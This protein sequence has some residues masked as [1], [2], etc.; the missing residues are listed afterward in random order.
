MDSE[1][2][3]VEE[4]DS[5]M[6]VFHE[7]NLFNGVIL[8]AEEDEIIYQSAFGSSNFEWG[9]P[10][11]TNTRFKMASITKVYTASL[12]MHLIERGKLSLDEVITD[13]LP[14]YPSATGD[15]I[16][17]EH[18]LVQSAGIPDY[19][20]LPGFLSTQAKLT[21]DKQ[22][23]VDFFA[24]LDLEFE[25]GTDWNYGNSG[26]YL[27]GLIVEEVTGMSYEQAMEHYILDPLGL[28]DTGY[29]ASGKV[30]DRLASGYVKT[31]EGYERA[32]FFHSSA[33]FSAGMMYATAEDMFRWTRALAAGE[34]IRNPY[35][36]Q[37]MITPQME[38]YG[39][40]LFVGEQRIGERDELVFSHS[41]NVNG[42]TS[43]LA[44]FSDSDYTLIIMDN[45]QQC[46][47]RIY[48]A[49]REV[50]FGG[51]APGVR[52][53][54]ADIAGKMIREEGVEKAIDYFRDQVKECGQEI[55]FSLRELTRLG[56]YYLER[57][58]PE[59][60]IPIL[61]FIAEFFPG[62]R[63]IQ[64]KLMNTYREIGK[65]PEYYDIREILDTDRKQ[66]DN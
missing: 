31:P 59:T 37:N 11:Q 39:F 58:Q 14:D 13:H 62:N 48:F 43:Q 53:P 25:P 52:Q 66:P 51:P 35:H 49:A 34:I 26:Y 42:F 28:E 18:L 23:F 12:V 40:G 2:E 5:L 61:E 10:N 16:T 36:L 17:I 8:V 21:H 22:E 7:Y 41:G 55:G 4:L 27:L 32:P 46:T 38:D 33:G 57:N 19:I 45:T 64:E 9:I 44:Y 60:A 24:H 63:E 65:Q 20:N 1:N 50:L 15:R 47:S 6:N 56:N 3:R 54:I 29:A 30:I